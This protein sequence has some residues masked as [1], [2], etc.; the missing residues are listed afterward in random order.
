MV[1]RARD[2]RLSRNRG[3]QR[4]SVPRGHRKHR[5][6]VRGVAEPDKGLLLRVV[7]PVYQHMVRPC[8]D[9]E[10]AQ[11]QRAIARGDRRHA[12]LRLEEWRQLREYLLLVV[13]YIDQFVVGKYTD[14]EC[15]HQ[16]R[17]VAGSAGKH[18][19]RYLDWPGQR[20]DPV[21]RVV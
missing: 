4:R 1:K 19:L 11:Q 16:H 6:A 15:G 5:H 10:P 13:R 12:L 14:F 9:A 21:L 2:F 18:P 3:D 7:R 8:A 17:A 20:P